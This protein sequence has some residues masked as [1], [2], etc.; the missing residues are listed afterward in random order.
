MPS[1][2][3]NRKANNARKT[4]GKMTYTAKRGDELKLVDTLWDAALAIPDDTTTNTA[5]ICV[6]ET[7]AGPGAHERNGRKI[8]LKSLRIRGTA[9]DLTGFGAVHLY[10]HTVLRLVLVWDKAPNGGTIPTWATIFGSVDKAGGIAVSTTQSNINPA[11]AS[12]FSVLRDWTVDIENNSASLMTNGGQSD[13]AFD[14]FVQLRDLET[15]YAAATA[16]Y[17]SIS[18]GGLLLCARVGDNS[19]THNTKLVNTSARLRFVE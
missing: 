5:I 15:V 6:N 10:A 2:T 3:A 14:E 4:G 13:V 9:Q 12:R 16:A 11:N 17:A 8:T 19:A 7:K 18:S 1:K